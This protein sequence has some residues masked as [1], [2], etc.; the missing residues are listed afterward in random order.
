MSSYNTIELPTEEKERYQ[1]KLELCG[2]KQICPYQLPGDAWIDDPI[3]WPSLE[4]PELYDYLIN[5]PG[6]FTR[7]AMKNRKS[8]EAYNQFTSGWVRTVQHYPVEHKSVGIIA[9][10][11]AEVTPSQRVNDEC[12]TPWVAL[13]MNDTVHITAAHCSCMAGLGESCTHIGALLFKIEAA[14]RSGYTR[15]SC[16]SEACKWNNDFVK[17]VKG[18]PI[19]KIKFYNAKATA[20]VRKRKNRKKNASVSLPPSWQDKKNL[21]VKLSQLETKPVVLHC[22]SGYCE[23]FVPKYTPPERAQLPTSLRLLYSS[24]NAK[25]NLV[26]LSEETLKTMSISSASL[27]YLYNQTK[28]QSKSQLWHEIRVGRITA[29]NAHDVLHTKLGNPSVSLVKRICSESKVSCTSVPSL[30]WSLDHEK[31]ALGQFS[32]LI[33]KIHT[34]HFEIQECGLKLCDSMPYIGASA[35]GLLTCQC[36]QKS[37]TLE[38]KCPYSLRESEA[39]EDAVKNNIFCVNHDKSLKNN[40]RYYTQV[41]L[42]L[43]VYNVE[44]GYFIVWTPKWMVYTEVCKDMAFISPMLLKL[45][46]FYLRNVILELLTRKLEQ[47]QEATKPTQE[48]IKHKTLYCYCKSEYN[49]QETWI[50]CDSTSCKWE[51]LHLKCVNLKRI[52][53]GK[54]YCPK[55]RKTQKGKY[56]FTFVP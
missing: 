44:H 1:K 51:W 46:E 27:T 43:Y 50:G 54:W 9:I 17:K 55:C 35:D 38:V 41:Q 10:F 20:K 16:T 18:K 56:V 2:L 22:F 42:Q 34:H 48:V 12:H 8:L 4:W 40:H 36:H 30:K 49:D 32:V 7:E 47:M 45:K 19:S 13:S 53:K 21:L 23:S 26:K 11:K 52:P 24:E 14:V 31:V 6:V 29:S 37:F 28:H 33:A 39:L 25:K 15:K 3:K 5:T